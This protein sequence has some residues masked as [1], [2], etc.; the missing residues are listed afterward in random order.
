VT[1]S[2]ASGSILSNVEC[3][4]LVQAILKSFLTRPVFESIRDHM[5]DQEGSLNHVV[6]L[7]KAVAERYL[8]VRY[9]YAGKQY[10]LKLLRGFHRLLN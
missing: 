1:T 8:Q 7:T 5:M 10:T 6:L 4:K 2:T 9:F 3:H